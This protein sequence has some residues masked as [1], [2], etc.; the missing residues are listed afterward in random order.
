M[1]GP[2]DAP[3]ALTPGKN[4]GSDWVGDWVGSTVCPGGSEGM[5]ISCPSRGLNPGPSSSNYE[6]V[7][8]V[9]YSLV[10]MFSTPFVS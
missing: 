9:F 5:K 2:I 1:S 4:T 10:F 8:P 3:T 6:Y 7:N